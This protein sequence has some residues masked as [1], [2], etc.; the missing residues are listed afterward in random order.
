M[1]RQRC[2]DALGYPAFEEAYRFLKALQVCVPAALLL[3]RDSGL[4]IDLRLCASACNL[5]SEEDIK[6]ETGG[7]NFEDV[8]DTDETT[9]S[10]LEAILGYEK[11]HFSTLIDQLIFM[12]ETHDVL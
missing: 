7:E 4:A 2:V 6:Y 8:I 9:N 3:A 1:L 11:V 5:Q 10:R 12:E